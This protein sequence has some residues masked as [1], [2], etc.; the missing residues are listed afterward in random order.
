MLGEDPDEAKE[1]DSYLQKPV[2]HRALV[3]LAGSFMNLLLPVLLFF[4][5]FFFLYGVP[6]NENKVGG[7]VQD[8]PA[9]EAGLQTG[10]IIVSINGEPVHNFDQITAIVEPRPG[11]EL[12]V[13]INR[14]GEIREITVQATRRPDTGDG[15]IGIVR[16][17]VKYQ[18]WGAFM[19]SLKHY[20]LILSLIFQTFTGQV[21]FD[22]TG[23]VGIVITMG[24]VAKQGLMNLFLLA[25]II[26]ISLGIIN[27]LPIPALD[28]GKLLFLLIELIRGKP[29]D[30]EKEGY[31]HLIGFALLMILMLA[32]TWNDLIRFNILP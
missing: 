1:T 24:E 19:A 12:D 13:L 2:P 31:I 4:I 11:Q 5:F 8:S 9:A 25:G 7:L 32:V 20:W 6:V 3:L 23:P 18:P 28:G 16:P 21:P 26:S 27:L 22:V 10:D 14:D 30:P 29:L 17:L 15:F